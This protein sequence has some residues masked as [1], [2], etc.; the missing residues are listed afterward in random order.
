MPRPREGGRWLPEQP[1]SPLLGVSSERGAQL[2]HVRAIKILL[3]TLL[4]G[5]LLFLFGE[6]PVPVPLRWLLGSAGLTCGPASYFRSIP[7]G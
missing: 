1:K 3:H 6:Q 7:W 2:L 5:V 4:S